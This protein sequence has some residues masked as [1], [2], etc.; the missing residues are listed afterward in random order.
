MRMHTRTERTARH[1]WAVKTIHTEY[2][3]QP[4]KQGP[5]QGTKQTGLVLTASWQTTPALSHTLPPC[6]P[7]SIQPLQIPPTP[8]YCMLLR[9]ITSV[10]KPL[11][12]HISLE[13][14]YFHVRLVDSP[15]DNNTRVLSRGTC[16]GQNI[17]LIAY[18]FHAAAS[19]IPNLPLFHFP[20][21]NSIIPV[22]PKPP[23]SSWVL[24][25]EISPFVPDMI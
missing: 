3:Q 1:G 16:K 11:H 17:P 7:L 14:A 24:T 15:P 23:S 13:N 8:I 21:I 10:Q 5:L 18:R 2:R 20:R 22:V 25:V 4:A 19:A 9:P 6:S 12:E